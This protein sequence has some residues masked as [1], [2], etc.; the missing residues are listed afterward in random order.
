MAA[1]NAI[2][3][4]EVAS[5]GNTKIIGIDGVARDVT[6][7]GLVYEGEQIVSDNPDTLFQIRYF[8]LPEA[9]A[10]SGVFAV[11]AD[12]SVIS[13]ISL[14]ETLFG[15]GYDLD[16]MD[17]AGGENQA[18]GSSGIPEDAAIYAESNVQNFERG[19]GVQSVDNTLNDTSFGIGD[20][21]DFTPS[22]L[23][24][25]DYNNPE[26]NLGDAPNSAPVALDETITKIADI[27]G[28]HNGQGTNNSGVFHVN[29]FVID[30]EF[31][32]AND[33]D[34]DGDTL[35]IASVTDGAYGTVSINEDGN[36]VYT[37]TEPGAQSA[38][39]DYDTFTYTVTDGINES[40]PATVTIDL[41]TGNVR[42]DNIVVTGL[43]DSQFV[44]GT[45][46]SDILVVSDTLD[47][48]NVS[49]IE[50]VQLSAH[51]TVTGSGDDLG[52]T[53][54]D[55]I[56][57]TSTNTLVIESTGGGDVTAQVT[58]D[59]SLI[60][61]EVVNIGDTYY[62]SYSDGIDSATLLIE[63]DT[64]IDVVS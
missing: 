2:G 1:T 25:G 45:D 16:F 27:N 44:I 50:A 58:V 17:T 38:V 8:A 22:E 20:V 41:D 51:A 11:L 48:A 57:A 40:D 39:D 34:A 3:R 54:D 10:Y 4:I 46:G 15:E 32:L 7:E 6:Y 47:L 61:G 42:T 52:I 23:V 55:V 49:D 37:S 43:A 26:D 62:T 18:R 60:Q 28:E 56:S 14:L 24:S 64:P 21:G 59:S 36:L 33:T 19:D 5:I 12:G 29:D 9:T 30:Q 13:D 31:L 53:I 63:I 35:S